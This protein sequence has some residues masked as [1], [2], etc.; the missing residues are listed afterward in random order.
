MT[1]AVIASVALHGSLLMPF[2]FLKN[3]QPQKIKTDKLLVELYGMIAE[4]QQAEHVPTKVIKQPPKK[5]VAQ[6]IS[7]IQ[8]R[9]VKE[10]KPITS[11]ST[12]HIPQAEKLVPALSQSSQTA[13]NESKSFTDTPQQ[14]TTLNIK[15]RNIDELKRYLAKIKKKIQSNLAY[16]EEAKRIGYEGM[17]VVRFTISNSGMIQPGSLIV[18]KSSGYPLLDANALKAAHDS[19]PFEQPAHTMEIAITLSFELKD[20]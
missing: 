12:V 13:V 16:P 4:R 5:V 14:Q 18:I 20:Q 8:Q 7:K 17:P 9:S 15:D 6:N 19:E 1:Y 11:E 2:L 3:H 10:N